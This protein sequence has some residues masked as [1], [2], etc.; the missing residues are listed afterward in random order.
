MDRFRYQVTPFKPINNLIPGKSLRRPFSSDL[1]KEEVFLCMKCGPV[2]RVMPDNKPAIR[3][4]G[5]NI[6]QLHREIKDVEDIKNILKPNTTEITDNAVNQ[7]NT[8]VEEPK[9]E[10][11]TEVIPEENN[12]TEEVT[13]SKEEE[14]VESEPEVVVEEPKT[15]ASTEVIPKEV[16][17]SEEPKEEE[18]VESEPEV[19]VVEEKEKQE[20]VEEVTTE[21]PMGLSNTSNNPNARPQQQQNYYKKNKYNKQ[22]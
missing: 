22:Q 18:V 14:V 11:S 9:T 16:T 8:V 12:V 21:I 5:S 4:T 19:I 13:P 20:E 7:D 3:V 15:E 10:A 17:L 1:T 6:D 2:F